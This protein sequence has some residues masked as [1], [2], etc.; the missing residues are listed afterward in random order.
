MTRNGYEACIETMSRT[1]ITER[2]LPS[3]LPLAAIALALSC[4]AAEPPPPVSAPTAPASLTDPALALAQELLPDV[5]AR[6]GAWP[7]SRDLVWPRIQR[8]VERALAADGAVPEPLLRFLARP[9][10]NAIIDEHL[11]GPR[12][13]A[14]G[15][16]P[17]LDRAKAHLNDLLLL[18]VIELPDAFALVLWKDRLPGRQ[19]PFAEVEPGLRENVKED[20]GRALFRTYLNDLRQEAKVEIYPPLEDRASTWPGL[21]EPPA[22]ALP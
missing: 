1:I 17:D 15:F 13:A 21:P 7:V 9:V 18:R 2:R 16:P 5:V 6:V 22:P 20:K 8:K 12:A 3:W 10:V 14:A 4:L 11:L 19:L